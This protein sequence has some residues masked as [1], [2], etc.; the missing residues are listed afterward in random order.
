MNDSGKL[1]RFEIGVKGHK[2]EIRRRNMAKSDS[3]FIRA[4]AI[5]SGSTYIETEIDLG[6]FVNLGVSKSTLMRIHN[7]AVQFADVTTGPAG[8]IYTLTTNGK[9]GWQV[10]TQTQTSLLEASDKSIVASGGLTLLGDPTSTAH[11]TSNNES[12]DVNPQAWTNGYLVGVD[13]L[14]LAVDTAGTVTTGEVIVSI[15]IECTLENATQASSVALAL[16][17]Q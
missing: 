14:F 6:S 15:V 11:P 7:I 10:C 8:A 16:S 9:I 1:Q 12:E 4:Q 5:T 13:A 2:P 17:Q 3:F